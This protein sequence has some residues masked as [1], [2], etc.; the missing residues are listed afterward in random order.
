[1]VAFGNPSP[2]S[3]DPNDNPT[4]RAQWISEILL[5]TRPFYATPIAGM[6]DDARAFLWNDQTKDPLDPTGVKDFGPLQ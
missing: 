4:T 1:M 5:T 3:S 2:N 6:L